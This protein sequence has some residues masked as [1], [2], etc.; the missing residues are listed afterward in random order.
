M[1][2]RLQPTLPGTWYVHASSSYIKSKKKTYL[3]KLERLS[4]RETY[5]TGITN[6]L[7]PCLEKHLNVYLQYNNRC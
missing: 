7:Q 5:K 4:S 3:T 2:S 6:G 1:T